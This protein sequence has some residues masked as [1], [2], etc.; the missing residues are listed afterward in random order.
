MELS[1]S[2][3]YRQNG[4]VILRELFTKEEVSVASDKISTHY[5]HKIGNGFDSLVVSYQCSDLDVFTYFTRHKKVYELLRQCVSD[6]VF[7]THSKLPLKLPYVGGFTPHQDAWFWYEYKH[8][9]NPSMCAS[10]FVALED[11]ND[12][13]GS[14]CIHGPRIRELLPHSDATVES[15]LT[16]KVKMELKAG[17]AV[18]M[19]GYT[20]HSSSTNKSSK[21]R[22]MLVGCYAVE[23]YTFELTNKNDPRAVINNVYVSEVKTDCN[24]NDLNVPMVTNYEWKR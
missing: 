4:Y 5:K 23:G 9:T 2:K 22:T 18:L 3:Q 16:E 7:L 1:Y 15:V 20:V 8:L 14:L 24:I 12:K 17:D 6:R 21:M 13:N 11:T 19:D 10:L